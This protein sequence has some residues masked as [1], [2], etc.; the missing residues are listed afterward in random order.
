MEASKTILQINGFLLMLHE[1][2]DL[3][4]KKE[5]WVMPFNVFPISYDANNCSCVH[6]AYCITNHFSLLAC[7]KALNSS[8]IILYNISMI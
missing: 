6:A 8:I 7:R 2:T 3:A 1:L 5:L 4:F